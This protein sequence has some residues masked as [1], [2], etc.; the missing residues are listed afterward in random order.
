MVASIWALLTIHGEYTVTMWLLCIAA[1]SKCNAI[2]THLTEGHSCRD[3][4]TVSAAAEIKHCYLIMGVI[5]KG[6]WF[7]CG[8][9]L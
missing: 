2:K 3:K 5:P 9:V 7:G 4:R 6:V 8:Q 1:L